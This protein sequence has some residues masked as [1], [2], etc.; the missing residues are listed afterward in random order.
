M[1][2]FMHKSI[3]IIG[4]P[5]LRILTYIKG[6]PDK[7]LLYK[8]HGHLRLKLFQTLIMHEIKEKKSTS[9]YCTYVGDNLVT[10]R[11]KK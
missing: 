8:N 7:G 6:S 1:C 3:E 11:S 4:R 5:P 9:G 2:Q 10:W